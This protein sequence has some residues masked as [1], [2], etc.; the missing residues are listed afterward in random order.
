[1][2]H[3]RLVQAENEGPFFPA[4]MLTDSDFNPHHHLNLANRP[5][6][7]R[8]CPVVRPFLPRHGAIGQA[9]ATIRSQCCSRHTD[10]VVH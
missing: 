9:C 3:L 8:V 7:S 5:R 6:F 10:T 1:V 4:P 2:P